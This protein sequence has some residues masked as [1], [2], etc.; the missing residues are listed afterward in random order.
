MPS[1]GGRVAREAR[2][3]SCQAPRLLSCWLRGIHPTTRLEKTFSLLTLIRLA[4]TGEPPSPKGKAR[5]LRRSLIR[6]TPRS[7]TNACRGRGRHCV[8]KG[9]YFSSGQ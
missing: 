9:D 1:L 2:R 4:L 7:I 5:R 6:K 3:V 8:W